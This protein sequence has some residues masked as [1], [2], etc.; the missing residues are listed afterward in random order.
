MTSTSNASVGASSP[1][2][3][4]DPLFH[5]ERDGH[6]AIVTLNRP[7]M[8]NSLGE[9]GDGQQF[10][11]TF[12]ALNEDFDVRCIILTGAGRAFSSGGN[13][14]AMHEA[15][16]AFE[17]GGTRLR[18]QYQT[19]VHR[20]ARAIY[21]LDLP[22]IAAVNGP[23]MGLGCDVACLA[24]IRI[25]SETARFGVPFLKLGLVPGDGGSWLLPRIIGHSRAAEMLFTSDVID[26]A[27][28]QEWGLVSRVVPAD[29]LM[30]EARTLAARIVDKAPHSLRLTKRL[31]RQAQTTSYDAALDLAASTQSLLHLSD[32]HRE[33]VAAIIEKRTARFVGR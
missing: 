30:A 18:D 20:I 10:A 14:K 29:R 8:L 4:S 25:A 24:D 17:G 3:S 7:Q 27:T 13:I 5:V 12:Q 15:S 2:A 16:G 9:L 23:A 33:G 26:A 22:L 19:N 32:D 1:S 21:D 6:L 28:A 11:S 31:M